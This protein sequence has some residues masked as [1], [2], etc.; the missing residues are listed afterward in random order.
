M[1][2]GQDHP[3]PHRNGKENSLS[4]YS[5]IVTTAFMAHRECHITPTLLYCL[6]CLVLIVESTLRHPGFMLCEKQVAEWKLWCDIVVQSEETVPAPKN[7]TQSSHGLKH[8][9]LEHRQDLLERW[10]GF[11]NGGWQNWKI[12]FLSIHLCIYPSIHSAIHRYHNCYIIQSGHWGN[13][14]VSQFSCHHLF[15]DTLTVNKYIL[16]QFNLICV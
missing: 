12:E 16:I 3:S 11:S 14:S 13:F 8:I 5:T 15:L 7:I 9:P 10:L 4:H 2:R 1:K 6:S